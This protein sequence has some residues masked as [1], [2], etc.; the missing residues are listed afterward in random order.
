[1]AERRRPRVLG[2]QR[3]AAD[4]LDGK[5]ANLAEIHKLINCCASGTVESNVTREQ[6]ER[7]LA[8]C[9]SHNS[10]Y[11]RAGEGDVQILLA[12]ILNNSTRSVMVFGDLNTSFGDVEVYS[13]SVVMQYNMSLEAVTISGVNVSDEAI[14]MLCEAMAK[15]RVNFIDFSNNPLEDEAGRSLAAL[16]HVNPYLRT[17][18]LDDTLIAEEVLDEIDVSCQFNQSNFEAN[19]GRV[20]PSN[21]AEEARIRHRIQNIIRSKQKQ[22]WYCVPHVL[23]M[24]PDGSLCLFSHT[25]MTSGSPDANADLYER[26]A[27]LF[28]SDG[29]SQKLPMPPKAGAS[30]RSPDEEDGRP[31]RLNRERR[32]LAKQVQGEKVPEIFSIWRKPLTALALAAAVTVAA[33]CASRLLRR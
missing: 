6:L 29:H 24:C 15:S 27:E 30:W 21:P 9:A 2:A 13:M 26:V 1:M 23:G 28:S 20:E 12:E 4:A 31:L 7:S 14:S 8:F 18:I 5:I 33:L 32:R 10:Q 19:G 22:I 25:P 17:V 3:T 16:A 11:T